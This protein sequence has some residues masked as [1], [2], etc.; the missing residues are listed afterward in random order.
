MYTEL[1]DRG[2]SRSPSIQ[3]HDLDRGYQKKLRMT[4]SSSTSGFNITNPWLHRWIYYFVSGFM[5]V[6]V[7]LRSILVFRNSPSFDQILSAL[8]GW[9]LA[10]LAN[11]LLAGRFPWLSRII[12]G[13]ELLLTQYL[14]IIT[15]V[16]FLAYLFAIPC[17]QVRQQF[18]QRGAILLLALSMFLTFLT[19]IQS[20]GL[21]DAIATVIVF[22]GGTL[23]LI[24]Y[25][26]LTR[27]ARAVQ[28]QQQKLVGELQ[29]TNDQLVF[30]SRQLQQ[31]SA[32]RERQRLARELHDSVTQ[33]IFSMTLTTQSAIILL[34]R[35]P[36]Q[37]VTLMDRLVQ[38]THNALSEMQ[39]LI[40][41]LAPENLAG[42]GFIAALRDHFTE[43][44]QL[45]DLSVQFEVSGSQPLNAREEQNLFRIVQE[46]LNNVV[47]HS[48][49]GQAIVRLCLDTKALLTIEDQGVGFDPRQATVDSGMGLAGM[50]ERAREIG[51]TLRVESSPGSGT[52]ITVLKDSGG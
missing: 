12:I 29:Q 46:A 15:Q 2:G 6:S 33:T 24:T 34:D 45:Y 8:A 21:Y 11:I 30:Y 37:V 1:D 22:F 52:R 41:K 32:G 28:E 23:F 13:L 10:L 19:L 16:D 17:M 18:T 31:L 36:K 48:G 39:I 50:Q 43:R 20:Y 27:R 44:K 38:L 14:L 35:D 42:D 25:I 9:F 4:T 3:Q 47:K 40:T 51:W 26:G 7:V 5:F 49:V